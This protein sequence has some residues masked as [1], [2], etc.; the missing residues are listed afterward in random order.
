METPLNLQSQVYPDGLSQ[1]KQEA[2]KVLQTL[3]LPNDITLGQLSRDVL[4]SFEGKEP[5][6]IQGGT[7]S[8]ISNLGHIP[9]GAVFCEMKRAATCHA[10][11]ISACVS[12]TPL[13]P[14]ASIDSAANMVRFES[15]IF[16]HAPP[17]AI[18]PTVRHVL[19]SDANLIDRSLIILEEQA[20]ATL[21]LDLRS[22]MQQP[23]NR[24][25]FLEIHLK[26]GSR[27]TLVELQRFNQHVSQTTEH[28]STIEKDAIL[29]HVIVTLGGGKTSRT[30]S[31]HTTGH[32]GE[33][34]HRHAILA[35]NT[36]DHHIKT[37][38]F[39]TAPHSKS[40]LAIKTVAQDR[41][42]ITTHSNVH[43]FS[44]AKHTVS[45]LGDHALI[46]DERA[47]A[48]A[49]PGMEI[50]A[51]DVQ[52]GHSASCSPINSNHLFYLQSRGF[53]TSE[54]EKTIILSF[55]ESITDEAEKITPIKELIEERWNLLHQTALDTGMHRADFP[56]LSKPIHGKPL[57]YLDNAATTQK[58]RAVINAITR[59]YEEDN[60]NIHRGLHELS[61]RATALY[62]AA[63]EKTA[64]FIHAKPGEL[65]FV[66]NATEGIN[67]VSQ[68]MGKNVVKK[69][70]CILLTQLEHHSN[71][72]PWQQLAR[73]TGAHIDVVP[74]TDEGLLDMKSLQEK[75]LK[76]P[77]ILAICHVSNVLGTINPIQDICDLAHQQG[78]LVV[79]DA[80]QSVPHMPVDVND[81]GCDALV[82]SGHKMLG[83][84]G[85]GAVFIKKSLLGKLPPYMGGG[86]MIKEVFLSD[87]T[88]FK[89]GPE[90]FEA[91]TPHIAG[92]IALGAA[93]DYLSSIG[94]DKVKAHHEALI[95]Y[96]YNQLSNIPHIKLYGP[97]DLKNRSG[98]IP[99]NLGD[100]HAH[101]VSTILDEE[102]IAVRAGHHCAMPL[103]ERLGIAST[104]RA[105]FYIYNSREDIDR[106]IAGIRKAISVF[107]L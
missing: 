106:L 2:V 40:N 67:L 29:T 18:L 3:S 107:R 98:V 96:A 50:E 81:L 47:K 32:G 8:L 74:I 45:H 88:T 35:S 33:V 90:R 99:F 105:S 76:K 15:G 75:L 94:M 97:K 19:V 51:N 25:G 12:Q 54:A 84:T 42:H 41:A 57:T 80:A 93:I 36:Q 91:G 104:C 58:P 68:T 72:V 49:I 53:S 87:E 83:P 14:S 100:I 31:Y 21:I 95:Q 43:I 26:P 11:L 102:G 52:A 82:F 22:A 16:L 34:V 66:R 5:T 28:I 38:V 10:N 55:L 101:D 86:G 78:T 37:K 39:H 46:I 103:M 89:D 70:D 60:A 59:F 77:K 71:I 92:A 69:G 20:H 63:R 24:S 9:S 4:L 1:A 73:Q 27:L 62:E 64:A 30:I 85:I 61:E 48:E 7:S 44:S 65:I 17:R 13:M 79:V 56:I 6:I 23:A